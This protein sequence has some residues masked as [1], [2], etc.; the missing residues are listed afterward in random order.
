M[1]ELRSDGEYLRL[2]NPAYELRLSYAADRIHRHLL[3]AGERQTVEFTAERMTSRQLE[4]GSRLVMVLRVSKRPDREI[5]YG[6]GG[7]VSEES[8][9]DGRVPLKVRWFNDSYLEVP[10]QAVRH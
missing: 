7:D 3:K 10:G 5:N 2:F 9:A 8:M 6:T 4:K 1:Y